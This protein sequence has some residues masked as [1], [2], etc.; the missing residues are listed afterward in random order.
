MASARDILK[1]IHRYARHES[2]P[3]FSIDSLEKYVLKFVHRYEDEHP[4]LA[5]L[6]GDRGQEVLHE[7]LNHLEDSGMVELHR[8]EISGLITDVYYSAFYSVEIQ[9]WYTRMN[10]HRELPFPG[11]SDLDVQIPN[12]LVQTVDVSKDLMHRLESGDAKPEQILLLMFPDRI[13]SIVIT[14]QTLREHLLPIVV[15]KVRDY[16]RTENNSSFTEKKLRAAF[17]TR[18]LLVQE[19]I[20]AALTSLNR[21]MESIT[22]P[23]DFQLHFWTQLSSIIVKEYAKKNEKLPLEHGYY[24]AAYILGYLVMFHKAQVQKD[25]QRDAARR[26]LCEGVQKPPYVFGIQDL[27]ELTDEHGVPLSKR[28]SG[29]EIKQ[30]VREM[31]HRPSETEISELV[32]IDTPDQKGLIVHSEQYV[33]LLRRQLKAAAPVLKQE[34]TSG[35]VSA[36]IDFRREDWIADDEAFERVVRE[37]VREEFP[38]LFGLADFKTLFLVIDGQELPDEQAAAYALIDQSRKATKSWSDILDLGRRDLLSDARLQLP[39]WMLIPI[40][41]GLVRILRIMFTSGTGM[42]AG[43]KNGNRKSPGSGHTGSDREAKLK[44][45][46]KALAAMQQQYLAP[47]Q[48]PEQRLKELSNSWNPLIDPE[49][50]R[51]LVEDVNSLC[52]D[53]LRK[54]RVVK[55]LQVPDHERIREQAKLIAGDET[56]HRVRR[57]KEFETYLE[58]YMITVLYRA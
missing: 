27:Q 50:Q 17:S 15:S 13:D 24:Q 6:I 40:L 34:L 21:A 54:M 53:R 3:R 12:E 44:E 45:F 7:G 14:V 16:L 4:E 36:L 42:N 52:R 2:G 33:P 5:S 10:E 46:R 55:T 37:R 32:T 19:E 30:W 58:L 1:I 48:T 18:E 23:N 26:T 31:L 11:E 35:M 47:E 22:N 51:N 57:R 28:V 20:Q 39:V 56:F 43:A 49:A 38:L 41:R 9:R 8:N 29:D 25:Q